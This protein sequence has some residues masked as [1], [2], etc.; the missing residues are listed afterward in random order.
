M[1]FRQNKHR[2][3]AWMLLFFSGMMC[4]VRASAQY[5]HPAFG[6]N[7]LFDLFTV[8]SRA[9]INEPVYT[10]ISDTAVYRIFDKLQ[11]GHL[12]GVVNNR[13]KSPLLLGVKLG[14]ALTRYSGNNVFAVT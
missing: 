8:T 1:S 10:L 5:V 11:E 3:L 2:S 13:A 9:R 6:N 4:C 12:Q 14:P 7:I